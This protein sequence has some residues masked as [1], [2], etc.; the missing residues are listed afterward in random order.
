[1][2]QSISFY[3]KIKAL[4]LACVTHRFSLKQG[5]RVILRWNKYKVKPQVE[6]FYCYGVKFY[7]MGVFPFNARRF[8]SCGYNSEP[9]YILKRN[10][11]Y[12]LAKLSEWIR[13]KLPAKIGDKIL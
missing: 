12:P 7:K 10:W 9:V 1:M 13:L 11:H 6:G 5:D 8:Y 2:K 4:V 3:G